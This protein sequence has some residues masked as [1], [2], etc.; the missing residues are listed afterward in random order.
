MI[1]LFA[2]DSRWKTIMFFITG[3][4]SIVYSALIFFGRDCLTPIMVMFPVL[5]FLM[6]IIRT[7]LII[8][9][10][11]VVAKLI[12]NID[13]LNEIGKNTLYLCGNEFIIRTLSSCLA[14]IIGLE[15]NLSS[16]LSAYIYTA[17][18]LIVCLKIVVHIEKR[19]LNSAAISLKFLR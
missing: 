15:I 12:E 7:L 3:G 16:P 14:G 17:V 1:A 19:L 11:L 18:L 13:L 2:L 4:L 6:P 8:W 9:A 5:V 10:N